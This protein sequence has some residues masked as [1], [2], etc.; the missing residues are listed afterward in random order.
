M[1]APAVA[2]SGSHLRHDVDDV[3]DDIVDDVV[4]DVDDDVVVVVDYVD[5]DNDLFYDDDLK[6]NNP[7]LGSL[8]RCFA[9]LGTKHSIAWEGAS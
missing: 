4:D 9:H 8:E 6:R 2:N 7:S 1:G 5:V 3:V